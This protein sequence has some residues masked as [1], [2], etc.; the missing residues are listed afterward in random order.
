[1]A[2]IGEY[3]LSIYHLLYNTPLYSFSEVKGSKKEFNVLILG[4]GWAG[5][6]AFK[7]TFWVG[8][9]INTELNITVAS[10]NAAEYEK[11]ISNSLPAFKR[12]ADTKGYAKVSKTH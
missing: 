6:E 9:G 12:F 11:K 4:N 3:R 10:N 2:K 5:N 8:Q 1:M 7:A